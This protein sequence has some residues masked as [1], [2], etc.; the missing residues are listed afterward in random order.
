MPVAELAA[1]RSFRL[2]E[3]DPAPPGY[4]EVQVRVEAVGICGSD[5]HYFLDG[6]IGDTP[7]AY[8]QV[9]GHE[10]AG[11][12]TVLGDGVSGWSVGDRV[13]LEPPVYCYHCE[14]CMSGRHNLCESVRFF[15]A[16]GDP[17]FFRDR[18][19]VPVA[20]L[21]ALPANL[22]FD[23]GSLF[24]PISIILH[25]FRF[26]Q[27]KMGETAAVFGAGP[28]GLSTIACLKLA[29]VKRIY[30][31][32]PV[33]ERRAM[34]ERLGADVSINPRETDPVA[35]ILKGTGRRGVDVTFDCATQEDTVN[36]SL[37]VTAPGGRAVITGV[38]Q[39]ER[40]QLDFHH[41]RRKELG[42]F[43]VRRANHTGEAAVALL[44]EHPRAFTPMITHTL[45]LTQV[46]RAFEM[47]GGYEDGVTKVVLRP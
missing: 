17:G 19:N 11:V 40:V 31:V 25:S 30:S 35:E 28:I 43:S 33:A 14:W 13:A 36:Q 9:L 2:R 8:P 16:P 4:G 27:P 44:E 3:Q 26:G 42:F 32:E 18:A 37:Y 7:A 34:A 20:N 21:I 45:P 22:S 5:L 46:Q 12:I 38:P 23:E 15:S 47:L 41:L 6:H 10:P 39:A 24:E 29:G 1:Y